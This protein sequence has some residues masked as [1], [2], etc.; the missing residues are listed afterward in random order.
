MKIKLTYKDDD[1][2]E[3]I[4][5][6]GISWWSVFKIYLL[7]WITL[8]AVFIVLYALAFLLWGVY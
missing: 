4:E 3:V 7:G 5:D 2:R 8:V 6:F 1:G